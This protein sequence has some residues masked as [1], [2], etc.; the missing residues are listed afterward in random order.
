MHLAISPC[1][2][3]TFAF[4]GL[5]HG[6]VACPAPEQTTYADIEELNRLCMEGAVDFCKI[7][8]GAYP[9]VRDRYQILDAGSALGFGCGPLVVARNEMTPEA[10]SKTTIAVPGR[11]TTATLLLSLWLGKDLQLVLMPFDQIMPAVARGHVAAGLIIHE[12][13]FTFA[14]HGLVSV[15]DLGAWWEGAF[16]LPIPLG[17]IA[18]KRS[19][20]AATIKTFDSALSASIQYAWSHRQET[21]PFMQHHAQEMDPS[22]MARHVDLYVNQFTSDLGKQGRQAIE[23][24]VTQARKRDLA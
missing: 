14:D 19:L 11:H 6:K 10:L 3:D 12:S 18:A 24:L 15:M 1:P 22:V 20:G 21:I 7:S 2:N 4:Y 16:G 13:R 9:E 17:G 23:F 5:L 8:F